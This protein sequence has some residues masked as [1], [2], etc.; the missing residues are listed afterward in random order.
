M[1]FPTSAEMWRPIDFSTEERERRDRRRL[2]VFGRIRSSTSIS[3]A[4][5]EMASLARRLEREYPDTNEGIGAVV[6]PFNVSQRTQEIGVR[7]AFG[8]GSGHILRLVVRQGLTQ[9]ALGLCLGLVG[10]FALTRVLG[11]LMIRITPTDPLTFISIALILTAV[12]VA[13]LVVPARRASSVDPVV[14]LRNE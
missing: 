7:V 9:L 6:K 5:V 1:K 2:E 3:R 8:A 14:A 4:R 12:A 10:A 11:N 13:T